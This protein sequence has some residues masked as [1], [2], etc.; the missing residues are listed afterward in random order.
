MNRKSDC[1]GCTACQQICPAHC[2]SMVPDEEGF[3]YPET[4]NTLC[5]QCGKCE[6]V[7]PI[8]NPPVPNG[9]TQTYVGYANHPQIRRQSSSGGIFSLAA[10]YVLKHNGVV[11]GAAFDDTF[12][13]RH[14]CVE[15]E[16]ELHKLRGSKYVQSSLDDTYAQVKR[17]LR[18]SRWVLFTGTACQIAGLKRYLGKAYEQLLT[19]DILCHGV[20]SPRIWK[21]YLEDQERKHHA[22]TTSVQ[23]RDKRLGW[24]I[25][26]MRILF[27]NG[28]EYA[29]PFSKDPF[30]EMFLSNIDLRPSCHDCR[31]KAFPRVSDITI[32]DCWGIER[33]MP[34]M[35]DDLGTSILLVHSAKGER[36][37]RA[38]RESL[39]VK[40]AEL[41]SVLPAG[42][43]S[44]KSVEMHPNREKFWAGVDRGEGID[45]L[46]KYV[47]KNFIQ[48]IAGLIR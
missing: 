21:R 27:E 40:N 48:K 17:C 20:P 30:M 36:L 37:F 11:F 3:L 22:K 5:I 9:K 34:E 39:T 13:V 8:Q 19:I 1:C 29:V 32:G 16:G 28:R 45:C 6:T 24:K 15:S 7:C 42:A 43:D 35:D 2:I 14:I 46:Q 25:F 47:R 12:A 23:F 41:D 26:S 38:I 10:D 4:D 44:R 31:F 33:Q 18:D